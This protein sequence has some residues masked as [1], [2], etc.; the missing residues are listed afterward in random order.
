MA[1]FQTE[2]EKLVKSAYGISEDKDLLLG[3]VGNM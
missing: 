1:Y 2:N 3:L